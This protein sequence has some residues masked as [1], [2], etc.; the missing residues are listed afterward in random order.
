MTQLQIEQGYGWG[1]GDAI[2]SIHLDYGE[3]H[4]KLKQIL[5]GYGCNKTITPKIRTCLR[6]SRRY[7]C[8]VQP[9]WFRKQAGELERGLK[10]IGVELQVMSLAPHEG[11]TNLHGFRG[12]KP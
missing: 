11:S 1:T 10:S 8:E 7:D 6:L 5:E 3:P 12:V 2:S 4:R 9:G